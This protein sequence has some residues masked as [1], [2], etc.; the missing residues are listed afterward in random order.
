VAN[1]TNPHGGPWGSKEELKHDEINAIV[2][3][4]IKAP[5]FAEG[6]SHAPTGDIALSGSMGHGFAFSTSDPFP[7]AGYLDVSSGLRLTAPFAG[8]FR[9]NSTVSFDVFGPVT[10]WNGA[11]A[12]L[13]IKTGVTAVW[14]S[15]SFL[16][17]NG[18]TNLNG[19]T[20]VRGALAV[21]SVA[22][23]GNPGSIEFET[24]TTLT[25]DIGSVMVSGGS[26]ELQG[27][28]VLTTDAGFN[29]HE[30][31]TWSWLSA[32]I[33]WDAGTSMN[34]AGPVTFT[35][36]TTYGSGTAPLLSPARPWTRRATRIAVTD[37]DVGDPIVKAIFSPFHGLTPVF[38]V[39]DGVGGASG[40]H[41]LLE[42]DPPPDE[43]TIT[44]VSIE[45][46]GQNN[47][48]VAAV[49]QYLVVRWLDGITNGYEVMSAA[50]DDLHTGPGGDWVTAKSTSIT[51][52]AHSTI[53]R[54]YRYGV[55]LLRIAWDAGIAS[56]GFF[57]NASA[58]GTTGHIAGT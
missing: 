57:L 50:T 45:S 43:S 39:K 12:L 28:T 26:V 4:L 5:N 27:T 47:A 11:S 34:A 10:L 42:F 6:S 44:S 36:A 32:V 58:V 17:A 38:Y 41:L 40:L 55:L 14:E 23:G 19:A 3:Q 15:G 48:N 21:K 49:P 1:F 24:G 18:T 22:N 53:D 56:M 16:N 51:I 31:G 13:D 25:G 30:H 2:E 54:S 35:G 29:A 7:F 46:Q 33:S 52:T 9:L 20:N 37:Y 8:S